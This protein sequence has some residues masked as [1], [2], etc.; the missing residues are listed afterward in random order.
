[1][2]RADLWGDWWGKVAGETCD[3]FYDVPTTVT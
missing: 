2:C 1:M 3:L